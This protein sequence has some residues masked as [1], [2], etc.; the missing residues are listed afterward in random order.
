MP[1]LLPTLP[2]LPNP[3]VGTSVEHTDRLSGLRSAYSPTTSAEQSAHTHRCPHGTSARNLPT[4]S[5]LRQMQHSFSAVSASTKGHTTHCTSS[6]CNASVLHD[7]KRDRTFS[8][9]LGRFIEC[10][11]M[12]AGLVGRRFSWC[13]V[14]FSECLGRFS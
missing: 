12:L 9:C 10:S 11:D 5:A 7:V 8:W 14:R 1:I 13:S 3:C 2:P 6:A 4:S